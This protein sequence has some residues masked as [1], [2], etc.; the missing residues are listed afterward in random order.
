M[1]HSF[2]PIY[3]LLMY[4]R[5]PSGISSMGN[6][7]IPFL[8]AFRCTWHLPSL[9]GVYIFTGYLSFPF[10]HL[11]L[12]W[13]HGAFIPPIVICA[14]VSYPTFGTHGHL[15]CPYLSLVHSLRFL[16]L[17]SLFTWILFISIMFCLF[18]LNHVFSR[19]VFQFYTV[20]D[21]KLSH[22]LFR[23]GKPCFPQTIY[24]NYHIY[25]GF[26]SYISETSAIKFIL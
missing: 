5:L 11:I 3:L 16:F 22:L 13:T 21:I 23:W 15:D 26:L 24:I 4:W 25:P 19:L 7:P 8:A 9:R 1:G 6:L 14:T 17:S 18:S 2:H 20:W 12:F 10:H